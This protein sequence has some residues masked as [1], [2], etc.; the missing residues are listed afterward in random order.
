MNTEQDI[1]TEQ[2]RRSEETV[3]PVLAEK[4]Q[5]ASEDAWSHI[6]SA[7]QLLEEESNEAESNPVD[8]QDHP[9]QTPTNQS[10]VDSTSVSTEERLG[11]NKVVT[12]GPV[13]ESLKEAVV[14]A[15]ETTRV[16]V[17]TEGPNKSQSMEF[18]LE[19]VLKHSIQGDH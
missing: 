2:D 17:P 5:T 16:E 1:R 7:F 9:T 13:A 14:S 15:D 12:Y 6:Y 3:P 10:Q 19:K 8:Q 18:N 4:G 11:D